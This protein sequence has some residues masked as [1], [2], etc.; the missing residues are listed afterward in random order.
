MAGVDA[1]RD[2]PLHGLLAEHIITH[3]RDECHVSSGPRRRH[4]LVRTLASR[5]DGELAPDHRL[6][7]LRNPIE[8][9]DHVGIGAAHDD[10]AAPH[11]SNL[12]LLWVGRQV[13]AYTMRPRP[14]T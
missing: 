9:D 5:S 10:D 3:P 8:L 6:T 4:R 1:V 2:E 11:T 13:P 12:W 7:R 14:T